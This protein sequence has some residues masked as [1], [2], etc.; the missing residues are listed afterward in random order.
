MSKLLSSSASALWFLLMASPASAFC[1][2]VTASYPGEYTDATQAGCYDTPGSHWLYWK[3][4]CVGYS[5]H[6]DASPRRQLSLEQATAVARRAFEQWTSTPCESGAAP[7]IEVMDLGPV[8]CDIAQYDR[9]GPNQH[10]IVFRD[11]DWEY[12]SFSD[13]AITTATFNAET[14]EI[15]DMDTEINSRDW[16]I[17]VD[18]KSQGTPL[19]RTGEI[20][21]AWVL[22]HEAGHFLGLAHSEQRDALMYAYYQ[23]ATALSSDDSAGICAIYPGGASKRRSTSTDAVPASA[24]DPTPRHGFSAVCDAADGGNEAP[25]ARRAS[26]MQCT[27][28]AQGPGSRSGGDGLLMAL[29]GAASWLVI[30]SRRYRVALFVLVCLSLVQGARASVSIAVTLEQLV[31]HS[32][33]AAVVLPFAQQSGWEN[34]RIVTHT[35]VSVESVVMGQLPREISLR[36]LGGRS[37]EIG[38]VVQGEAAFR[39]GRLSLVFLTHNGPDYEVTARGQGQFSLVG[40]PQQRLRLSAMPAGELL[41]SK[42]AGPSARELLDGRVLDDALRE[43]AHR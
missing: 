10:I 28:T 36:T 17:V 13:V 32:D 23:R 22:A 15:Y 6:Q 18:P 30:R 38:Q 21:L 11:D 16:N 29:L 37:D 33:A 7:S 3:G 39:V 26:S 41:S 34:G 8:A 35:Q 31:K 2:T 40:D 42:A 14:G 19:S 27:A 4:S 20:D 9:A 25:R 12:G 1:R 43:L 24:C 5:L